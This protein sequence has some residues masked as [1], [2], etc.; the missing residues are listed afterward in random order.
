VS[1]ATSSTICG[2]TW[3]QLAPDLITPQRDKNDMIE[4]IDRHD[5]IEPI[6]RHEPID[7]SD[8]ADPIDRTEPTDPIDRTEPLEP[9]DRT[10]SSDDIG[11]LLVS[12]FA[13]IEQDAKANVPKGDADER[14]KARAADADERR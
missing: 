12:G 13:R 9:I 2:S 11:H 6:D 8:P 3:P 1:P 10:E 5:M 7:S 14:H 4:P